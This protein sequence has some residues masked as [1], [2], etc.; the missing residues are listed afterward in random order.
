MAYVEASQAPLRKTGQIKLH[1]PA[2]F[3]GM[4][5]AGA[6]V[7]ECLDVL[8]DEVKPGYRGLVEE[9]PHGVTHFALHCSAPGEIEARRWRTR[10]RA[11]PAGG[12]RSGARKRTGVCEEQGDLSLTPPTADGQPQ[13]LVRTR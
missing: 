3:A 9:L 12:G 1:G 13:P 11:R 7:A 5:K 4:R 2:A 6:L 8:A 10:E